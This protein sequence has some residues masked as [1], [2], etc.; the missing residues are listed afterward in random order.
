ML[1]SPAKHIFD[2]NQNDDS[3]GTKVTYKY[4]AEGIHGYMTYMLCEAVVPTE[5]DGNGREH[6]E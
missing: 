4:P 5:R 3:D 1:Q 2:G 6:D